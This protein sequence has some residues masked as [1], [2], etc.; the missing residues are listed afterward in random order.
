MLACLSASATRPVSVQGVMGFPEV[1]VEV[2]LLLG[3][4]VPPWAYSQ[5]T[6]A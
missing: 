5:P 1:Q 6:L 3:H 2:S 4:S